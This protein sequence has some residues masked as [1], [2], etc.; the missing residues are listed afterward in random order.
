MTGRAEGYYSDFRGGPQE[1]VSA[2]KYGYLFQ[3]QW[4]SWQRKRRGSPGLDLP[5]AAF[6]T[7]LENHD[8]IANS[9]RGLRA[10]ELTGPG[11]YRAMTALWLLMPGT[12]M[13]FMGQEFA[14]SAPFL[15]FADHHPELARLVHEGR[16]EFLCQSPSIADPSV[17]A[18]LA[19]PHDPRT[20]ECCKLDFTERQTNAPLYRL[21]KDLLTLRKQDVV[22]RTQRPRGVDGAVLGDQAFLLRFFANDG[23]DRLLLVN[24]GRDLH[25]QA[26]PE[27]LLAAPAGARWELLFSTEDPVYGGCG[28]APIETDDNGWRIAGEAAVV[29]APEAHVHSE[30]YPHQTRSESGKTRIVY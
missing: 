7:Y 28:T 5:P 14:A 10:H 2:A 15:Y 19:L 13:L 11:R 22:F 4:N 27:P 18:T 9:A 20:F 25:L 30:E 6:V 21:T 3:G 1:F 16:F 12:P 29:L 17:K 24:F 23:M 26:C 8:Q